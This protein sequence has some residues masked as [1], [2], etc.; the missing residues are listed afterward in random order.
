M[1]TSILLW[2]LMLILNLHVQAVWN[3]TMISRFYPLIHLLCWGLPTSLAALAVASGRISYS[4]G[5]SCLLDP[6]AANMLVFLPLATLIVPAILIHLATTGWIAWRSIRDRRG[7][8][9]DVGAEAAVAAATVKANPQVV[10]TPD[11]A[12]GT[13]VAS[14]SVARRSSHTSV[15][16]LRPSVD[17][18]RGAVSM[19]AVRPPRGVG[20]AGSVDFGRRKKVQAITPQSEVK[21]V[22]VWSVQGRIVVMGVGVVVIM[23][24]VWMTYNVDIRQ[25]TAV[26][27]N[28]SSPPTLQPFHPLETWVACMMGTSLPNT[29]ITNVTSSASRQDECYGILASTVPPPW[30]ALAMEAVVSLPGTM[31]FIIFFLNS[32]LLREWADLL[33]CCRGRVLGKDGSGQANVTGRARGGTGGTDTTAGDDVTS[34]ANVGRLGL[35]DDDGGDE[36]WNSDGAY[37]SWTSSGVRGPAGTGAVGLRDRRRR[38]RD[39]PDGVLGV[40][41]GIQMVD[42]KDSK[43]RWSAGSSRLDGFRFF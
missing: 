6:S 10:V 23:L 29:T 13:T 38:S 17:V 31:A 43:M 8:A 25:L 16:V 42:L 15:T 21:I 19:D 32:A 11:W 3:S 37:S 27:R 28:L 33:G 22:G 5:T 12:S 7:A 1:A 41:E 39:G 26:A 18:H 35:D 20:A 4:Y 14:S 9:P 2:I 34:V 24:A 40:G 36:G 30:R